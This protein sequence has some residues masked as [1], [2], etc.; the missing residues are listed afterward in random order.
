MRLSNF[1]FP[2]IKSVATKL[3]SAPLPLGPFAAYKG[4]TTP[5]AFPRPSPTC[6]MTSPA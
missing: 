3:K 5:Q 2:G 1:P 6:V 4:T